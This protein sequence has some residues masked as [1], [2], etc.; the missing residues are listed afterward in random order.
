MNHLLEDV[1]PLYIT[2]C[3]YCKNPIDNLSCLDAGY[4][5]TGWLG[6]ECN[7]CGKHLGHRDNPNLYTNFE[8]IRGL[9]EHI[10]ESA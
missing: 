3:W 4:D 8:I 10:I 9:C 1:Q 5:D 2:H 7:H 6:Y